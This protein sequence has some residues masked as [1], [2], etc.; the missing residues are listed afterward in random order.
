MSTLLRTSF[1]V[2]LCA[3]AAISAKAQGVVY[4]SDIYYSQD[5]PPQY[6][7]MLV[8]SGAQTGD[9]VNL[10]GTDRFMTGF[11]CG[12]LASG[13]NSGATAQVS[14]YDAGTST[15]TSIGTP[16]LLF[17]TTLSIPVNNS[18]VGLMLPC[19][20]SYL[21]GGLIIPD[22]LIWT[23]TFNFSSGTVSLLA[24]NPMPSRGGSYADYVTYNNGT[25]SLLGNVDAPGGYVN[26]V[27]TITAVPE[28]STFA[29]LCFGGLASMV[30]IRRRK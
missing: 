12:Y 4:Q 13:I 14:F 17:K 21:N 18:T 16:Q 1:A 28:P 29:L 30:L 15:E 9:M 24:G 3:T 5:N 11:G 10:E 8:N 23:V 20:Q 25:W 19:D 22:K 2:L 26:F 6:F 7:K 27:S